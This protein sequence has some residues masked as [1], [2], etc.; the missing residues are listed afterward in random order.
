M[1]TR[2]GILDL[3]AKQGWKSYCVEEVLFNYRKHG[4]SMIDRV[5]KKHN[6]VHWIQTIHSGFTFKKSFR[7]NYDKAQK[8]EKIT[9]HQL[10][11]FQTQRLNI[12]NISSFLDLFLCFHSTNDHYVPMIS[13]LQK[14]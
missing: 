9:K 12:K 4:H 8:L 3:L 1:V 10:A 14:Y 6:I 7:Y 11:S 2:L 13:L 5:M